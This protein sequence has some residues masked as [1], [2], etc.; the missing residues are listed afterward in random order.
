MAGAQ[1]RTVHCRSTRRSPDLEIRTNGVS[2][3][4]SAADLVGHDA[5]GPP[6]RPLTAHELIQMA[7]AARRARPQRAGAIVL[8]GAGQE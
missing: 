2:R 7:Q 1:A 3:R 8:P 4:R 6:G 5:A